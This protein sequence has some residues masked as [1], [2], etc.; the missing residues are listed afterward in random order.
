M[1]IAKDLGFSRKTKGKGRKIRSQPPSFGTAA[2]HEISQK[3]FSAKFHCCPIHSA[4]SSAK[5]Q[6]GVSQ[7]GHVPKQDLA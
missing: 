5:A 1:E 7:Q 2:F 4:A 3:F 6:R